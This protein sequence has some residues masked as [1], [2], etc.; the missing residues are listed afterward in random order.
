VDG[1]AAT[2]GG[3]LKAIVVAAAPWPPISPL[4]L[5][6]NRLGDQL[7]GGAGFVPA[8][9]VDH[10]DSARSDV[11]RVEHLDRGLL[12]GGEGEGRD[13]G[14]REPSRHDGEGRGELQTLVYAVEHGVVV[15]GDPVERS[16]RGG[17]R[18]PSIQGRASRASTPATGAHCFGKAIW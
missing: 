5:G 11:G 17:A 14:H 15:G 4:G 7:G 13:H 12:V 10:V 8:T 16:V 2:A 3:S 6:G 9:P 1:V 18:R